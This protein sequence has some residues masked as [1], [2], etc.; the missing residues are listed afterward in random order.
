MDS[1]YNVNNQKPV[2]A[3]EGKS[4]EAKK[5]KIAEAKKASKA[6]AKKAK[7]AVESIKVS[8]LRVTPQTNEC[9]VKDGD[10]SFMEI[11]TSSIV[12]TLETS[13]PK[14]A[15]SLVSAKSIL[16]HFLSLD[17]VS[18]GKP[19]R[20][21]TIY[22][23][24]VL[25]TSSTFS[26]SRAGQ[27]FVELPDILAKSQK[28]T[29]TFRKLSPKVSNLISEKGKRDELVAQR[30]ALSEE[31]TQLNISYGAKEEV[32]R[33]L[34]AEVD[35]HEADLESLLEKG[36][37]LKSS[38]ALF[39]PDVECLGVR[40]MAQKD[41][42][43]ALVSSLQDARNWQVDCCMRWNKLRQVIILLE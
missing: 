1:M 3:K 19:Q 24:S 35:Q 13:F 8:P 6:E 25:Q 30:T 32:I 9:D 31:L 29:V 40:L 39:G 21:S 26:Q 28:A 15:L 20:S 12:S 36:E 16:C 17:L 7:K 14:E 34:K 27:M 23:L 38:I 43:I 4:K 37:A 18:F 41:N 5:A 33:K 22:A 2:K 10:L 42:F 11:D